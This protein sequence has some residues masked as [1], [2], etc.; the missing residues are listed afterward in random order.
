MP[1]IGGQGQSAVATE[2]KQ[3]G[4]GYAFKVNATV[5]QKYKTWARYF[6]FDLNAGS[7]FNDEA[8]CIGS[9]L[10]FLAVMRQCG[11]HKYHAGFCE[12][13]DDRAKALLRRSE[14]DDMCYV[15]HGD[16]RELVYAIPEIISHYGESPQYAIGSVLCDPNG[17]N[18]PIDELAWLS[19]ECTKMDLIIH[20]NSTSSKRQRNGIKPDERSLEQVI[21]ELGKRHWLI[22]EPSAMHQFTLLV[23]RNMRAG[24]YKSLGFHHLDS[25]K[26]MDLL[27]KC[28]LTRDQYKQLAGQGDLLA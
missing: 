12:L 11:I 24:D 28:D 3:R 8:G 25:A 9:P 4:L 15:H 23:G 10:T 26:G 14:L 22:R 16:N 18:I 7:G 5:F 17:T 6:H 1:A 27:N 20:W 19:G 2:L 21:A 13:N